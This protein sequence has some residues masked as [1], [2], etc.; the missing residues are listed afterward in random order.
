MELYDPEYIL[1]LLESIEK[2]NSNFN[3]IAFSTRQ[4]FFVDAM[5]PYENGKPGVGNKLAFEMFI[6]KSKPGYYI[7]IDVNDF[8]KINNISHI[9]GDIAIK[10]IGKALRDA[11]FKITESK[12][13]RSGGDEFLLYCVNRENIYF[14]IE[15]A[16]TELDKLDLVNKITLSFGIGISYE[17]AEKA[18]IIA[19]NK[20]TNIINHLIHSN[21]VD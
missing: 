16:I 17:D 4:Y 2:Q 21:L 20:K 3:G 19:K 15:N 8:K 12:L 13:F 5:I 11:T 14:F 10:N 18:L 7:S 1:Y 9:I 6:R